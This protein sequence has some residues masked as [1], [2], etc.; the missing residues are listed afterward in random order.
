MSTPLV[1]CIMPTRD[2]RR[3][4]AQAIRYFMR[5]DYPAR[6]LLVVDDGE[7][8]VE[9]LVPDDE[10]VRYV[11]LSS[12]LSLGAK[13]NLACERARGELI[14][15][16]DDDDWIAPTRLSVQ[17]AELVRGRADVCGAGDL[18]HY[19]LNGG[20]AWRYRWGG[21]GHPW[22]AGGT[23]A[24]RRSAWRAR[25]FPDADVGEDTAFVDGLDPGRVRPLA[26][27]SFY[28]ALLHDANT[29]GKDLSDPRWDRRPLDEVTQRLGSDTGFY[30]ALRNGGRRPAAPPARAASVTFAAPL[31]VYDGYGSMAEYIALGMARAGAT[32][33]VVPLDYDPAG[34]TEEARALVDRSQPEPGAPVLCSCWPRADLDRF[35][36]AEE[37]FVHTMWETNRL[38]AG[39]PARLNRAR[40]LI[41]PTRFVAG[42]CRA[43]G[44]HVPSEVIPEG[45]DPAVYHSEPRP[46][47][48]GLTTLIVGTLVDRKNTRVGIAAWHRA[49]EGDPTARLIVKTRFGYGDCQID[50]PRIE[51]VDSNESTRGIAHWYRRADVLLA[52]GNE[53]F[54]LPL[55]EGMATG[56]PV[57]AL[58]SEGQSDTVAAAGDRVLSVQPR[59]WVRYEDRE[60]GRAGVRGVPAV[61]EVANLLRWVDRHRDEARAVGGAAAEWVPRHRNVWRK[62][63]AVLEA[64]ERRLSP[65]RPLRRARVLWVPSWGSPCG[66]ARYAAELRAALPGL[67]VGARPPRPATTRTLHVQHEPSLFDEPALA[68]RL[69]DARDRG[70]RVAVTEHMVARRA[71]AFEGAADALVATTAAGAA[72]LRRRWPDKRVEHIPPGCPTWFPQRKRK[73][74]RVIGAFGLLERRKGFWRLLDVVR[75]LSGTELIVFCHARSPALE[76]AFDEAAA[77]LPVRRVAA[78]GDEEALAGSLAASADVLAFWYDEAPSAATSGA[79]RTGLAT[80]VPVLTSQTVWFSEVAE[81]TYQP[82]ALV[83]GVE[84]LLTDDPLRRRLVARARDFCARH[85]WR[86]IGERHV[87]LWTALEAS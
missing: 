74:G 23:L 41:V 9:D 25:P 46:E 71:H 32:V 52:L 82:D 37:L 30:V 54:G 10:R 12:R 69:E 40:A 6:E 62:G 11:S 14:A 78:L 29:A 22:V 68:R 2:R 86:R 65:P 16:W 84:R 80:G 63:P 87:A 61:A 7:D 85:S 38:P 49:F 66:L 72:E 83:E 21:N 3:F 48:E 47:R 1:S 19:D 79:V 17:V 81:V 44:V 64:M 67:E 55:V 73:R 24:Y 57:I 77:G 50:D 26:D 75:D 58:D 20:A 31:M 39:W 59:K 15:H 43:S 53:G 8:R 36:R 33:N 5:Q 56:L 27:T 13:R 45:I 76:R 4:V 60:L 51:V 70:V 35:G 34:L 18:L 28:I 42:V